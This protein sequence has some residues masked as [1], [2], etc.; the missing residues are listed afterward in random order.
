MSSSQKVL[1]VEDHPYMRFG[2]AIALQQAGYEVFEAD[3]EQTAWELATQTVLAGAIVDLKIPLSP[4]EVK[5]SPQNGLHLGKRLKSAFPDI[6]LVFHTQYAE[7]APEVTEMIIHGTRGLAYLSKENPKE[8]L[9]KGLKKAIDGDLVI[10][11]R[12]LANNNPIRE[13]FLTSLSDE[14]RPYLEN[15]CKVLRAGTEVT[16]QEYEVLKLVAA[17]RSQKG[18]ARQLN[19][20]IPTVV[21]HI[22]RIYA[23]LQLDDIPDTLRQNA[24]LV[25]GYTM[26]QL[27]F[28]RA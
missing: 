9:L 24:L 27:D 12:F 10:E 18:I 13:V 11:T 20:A 15:I 8:S 16:P 7:F 3:N 25:K 23:K 17:G 28:D 14:E 22:G 19:I 4:N 5:S 21:S 2:L 6:G 1:I 26:Y